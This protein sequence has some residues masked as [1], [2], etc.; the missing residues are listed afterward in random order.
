[1]Y[2]SWILW[3]YFGFYRLSVYIIYFLNLTKSSILILFSVHNVLFFKECMQ[4]CI[5]TEA[6]MSSNKI[7]PIKTTD[8]RIALAKAKI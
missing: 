3:D 8:L 5:I 2:F 1:M 6:V 4:S 7:L